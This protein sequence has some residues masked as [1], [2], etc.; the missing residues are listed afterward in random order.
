MKQ[1]LE[2]RAGTTWPELR[3]GARGPRRAVSVLIFHDL[4]DRKVPF[5]DR[6]AILREWRDTRIVRTRGL[7]HHKILRAPEVVAEAVS[8]LAAGSAAESAASP[9]EK[10][11][12]RGARRDP[13]R[14]LSPRLA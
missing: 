4:K 3:I 8:F 11:G 7:G 14:R 12:L 9:K 10:P 1:L 6:E 13:A 2:S 5:R